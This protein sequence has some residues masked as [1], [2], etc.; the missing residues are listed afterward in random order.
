MP[1]SKEKNN[2]SIH[3]E[4][5]RVVFPRYHLSLPKNFRHT[6]PDSRLIANQGYAITGLPVPVYFW[7]IIFL[8]PISSV[9][10]SG[11]LRSLF[12]AGVLSLRPTL[13]FQCFGNLLLPKNDLINLVIKWIISGNSEKS[14]MCFSLMFLDFWDRFMLFFVILEGGIYSL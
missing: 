1:T 13:L 9:I 10:Y 3:S 5:E 6:H 4:D 11:D 8:R 2:P 14:I 7:S 12:T